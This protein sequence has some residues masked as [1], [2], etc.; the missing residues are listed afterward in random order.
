MS[1]RPVECRFVSSGQWGTDSGLSNVSCVLTEN[2]VHHKDGLIKRPTSC[3]GLSIPLIYT[4]HEA[5][6]Y[7]VEVNTRQDRS[8]KPQKKF[9]KRGN[10]EGIKMLHRV[11]PPCALKCV[12]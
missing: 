1:C 8:G 3:P 5:D 9:S 2:D 4:S 7:V 10:A 11:T 12:L 6:R